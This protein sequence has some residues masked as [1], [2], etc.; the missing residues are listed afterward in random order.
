ME[1][2]DTNVSISKKYVQAAWNK[3]EE[4][5]RPQFMVKYFSKFAINEL[6]NMFLQMPKE[7]YALRQENGWHEVLLE[8]NSI[9]ES[10]CKK[11]LAAN[12]ISSYDIKKEKSILYAGDIEK[13]VARVKAKR[14]V[15]NMELRDIQAA[16]WAREQKKKI[17]DDKKRRIADVLMEKMTPMILKNSAQKQNGYNLGTPEI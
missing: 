1:V 13:Y 7:Y 15:M 12:Y 6:Q 10:L 16:E 14:Q 4:K 9:N 8:K 11:L 2:K 17:T 5:D 3:L